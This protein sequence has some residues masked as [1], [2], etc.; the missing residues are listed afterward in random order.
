MLKHR[1]TVCDR[2]IDALRYAL[3]V[4]QDGNDFN[5]RVVQPLNHRIVV[6]T[7]PRGWRN[8]SDSGG[9][10]D[11]PPPATVATALGG[12]LQQAQTSWWSPPASEQPTTR[13]AAARPSGCTD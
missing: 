5:N 9:G 11:P 3:A 2:Q 8:S 6:Q 1:E 7:P 13:Q 12:P 10:G 4:S